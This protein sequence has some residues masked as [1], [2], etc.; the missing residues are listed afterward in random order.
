MITGISNVV[1]HLRSYKGFKTSQVFEYP[2]QNAPLHD[3]GNIFLLFLFYVSETI[4]GKQSY[5]Y[6]QGIYGGPDVENIYKEME[7]KNQ[8]EFVF[9]ILSLTYNNL[10]FFL[11]HFCSLH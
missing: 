1:T 9:C 6:Q 4:L 3:Q 10:Y 7:R 11:S 5:Q 8:I 2:L